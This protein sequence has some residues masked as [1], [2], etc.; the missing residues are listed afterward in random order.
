MK[1]S[2]FALRLPDTWSQAIHAHI[3]IHNDNN[4]NKSK[5]VYGYIQILHYVPRSLQILRNNHLNP[6][7]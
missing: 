1:T 6:I 3:H 5:L 4:N 7:T 2:D